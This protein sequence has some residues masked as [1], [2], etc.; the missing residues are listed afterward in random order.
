MESVSNAELMELI[1]ILRSSLDTL[2][3]FWLT[4]TF[5][6][7]AASFLAGPKLTFGF[8]VL[9]SLLYLLATLMVMSRWF[10]EGQEI[11]M[12]IE[13]LQARDLPY[14]IPWA[15]VVFRSALILLGTV[16]ALIFLYHNRKEEH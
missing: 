8:R 6:V 7:V 2:L 9:V 11:F 1:I 10:S 15:S 4:T 12:L 16:T 3:Q 14:G 5:A 13:A